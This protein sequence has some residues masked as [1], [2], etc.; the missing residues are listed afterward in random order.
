MA[1]VPDM[2]QG[3]Y[4]KVPNGKDDSKGGILS[5]LKNSK[6]LKDIIKTGGE[7]LASLSRCTIKPKGTP[8]R[9]VWAKAP[10]FFYIYSNGLLA[11]EKGA[12]NYSTYFDPTNGRSLLDGEIES[13]FPIASRKA[14]EATLR[15]KCESVLGVIDYYVTLKNQ[16]DFKGYVRLSDNLKYDAKFYGVVGGT[17]TNPV[18]LSNVNPQG[19]TVPPLDQRP[20]LP[21]ANQAGAGNLA[22]LA[23]I[24]FLL[25]R[26]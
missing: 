11:N 16:Q 5:F 26:G 9:E 17:Y 23:L 18:V 19:G 8:H 15:K 1:N 3:N 12:I 10:K 22:S 21:E 20:N 24:G 6:A 25:S 4:E 14:L 13:A 2:P 7:I